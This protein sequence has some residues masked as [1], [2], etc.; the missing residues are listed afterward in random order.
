MNNILSPWPL[1]LLWLLV[2]IGDPVIF[3]PLSQIWLSR[4]TYKV[5]RN[6]NFA[7]YIGTFIKFETYLVNFTKD[8][9][10]PDI[11]KYFKEVDTTQ[12]I[13]DTSKVRTTPNHYNCLEWYWWRLSQQYKRIQSEVEY[14]GCIYSAVHKCFFNYSRSYGL[15]S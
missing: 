3:K 5:T 8:L 9:N 7:P 15:P 10:P 13:W 2:H 6:V 1:E 12:L 4:S 14:W 11:M